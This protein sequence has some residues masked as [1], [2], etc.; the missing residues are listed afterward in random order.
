MRRIL[1]TCFVCVL[2]LSFGSAQKQKPW[3]EWSKKDAEKTLNDSAWGQTQTEGETS[4]PTDTS[5]ITQVSA[6]RAANRALESS[7][8]SGQSKQARMI[9]YRIRLLSA[10]PIRQ[11][12]A[13]MILLSQEKPDENLAS[14][15]QA[16]VDRDFSEYIVVAVTIETTDKRLADPVM[17]AFT[18]ATAEALRQSAYLERKDGKRL[19]LM[20]YRAPTADGMGA[21]FVFQRMVDG[22]PFLKADSENVR[23]VAELGKRLKL[24]SKYKL[25]DMMYDGK[26]EY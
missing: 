16:F 1:S 6:P 15:L 19:T 10:K 23:F 12:F 4:T 18:S 5:A 11:G 7:G 22:E 13:R 8:E 17:Q 25:S 24:N 2:F 3:T 9:K 14:Q 21:K 20:D 26:L